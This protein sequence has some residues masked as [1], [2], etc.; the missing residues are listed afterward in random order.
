[1]TSDDIDLKTNGDVNYKTDI[2]DFYNFLHDGSRISDP[3]TW[4][5]QLESVF[6]VDGFLKY[7]A[8]NNTIQN[9]DT[10]GKMPHNYY[11]YHDPADDL[12]KWI[13]WDNNEAFQNGKQGGAVSFGMTEVSDSWP[14]ISYIIAQEEYETIYKQYIQDFIN[15]P[16]SSSNMN[17]ILDDHQ[18]LLENSASNERSGYSFVNGQFASG[19]AGLKSHNT[20]RISAANAYID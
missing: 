18:S 4:K 1:M 10:Y 8:V 9:W 6:D 20:A 17:T 5:D 19:I 3:D 13:V 7:L 11:L 12:I 14:L 15:G 16:F 2:Q